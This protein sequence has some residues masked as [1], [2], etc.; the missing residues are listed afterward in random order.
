MTEAGSNVQPGPSA[1]HKV[2]E[3]K[4]QDITK[5]LQNIHDKTKIT[6]TEPNYLD[7]EKGNTEEWNQ[8]L[9]Q[10]KSTHQKGTE[11]SNKAFN[12]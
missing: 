7:E 9:D 6:A 5:Q 10:Q 12:R 1:L 11:D 4:P 3:H 2:E 8:N